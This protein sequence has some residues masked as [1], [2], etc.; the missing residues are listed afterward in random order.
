MRH[1]LRDEPGGSL[2]PEDGFVLGAVTSP[3]LGIATQVSIRAIE[4]RTGIGFGNPA[5][6]DPLA[7]GN[8]SVSGDEPCRC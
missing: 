6:V 5:A 4:Q 2:L 3:Q 7:R 8:E 1:R